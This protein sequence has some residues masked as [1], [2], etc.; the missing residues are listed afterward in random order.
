MRLKFAQQTRKGIES[1]SLC[2]DNS[3][4]IKRKIS[5]SR[6]AADFDR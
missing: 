2:G 4:S 6:F 5:V 3:L 1:A